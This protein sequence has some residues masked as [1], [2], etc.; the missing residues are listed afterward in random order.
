MRQF[1]SITHVSRRFSRGSREDPHPRRDSVAQPPA[2]RAACRARVGSRRSRGRGVGCARGG[3][4]RPRG[5]VRRSE[6][7]FAGPEAARSGGRDRRVAAGSRRTE[8]PRAAD[9]RRRVERERV[10]DRHGLCPALSPHPRF[11]KRT[12]SSS[13]LVRRSRWRARRPPEA[14]PQAARSP[15][16]CPGRAFDT[17]AGRR[18]ARASASGFRHAAGR[19]RRQGAGAQG[20]AARSGAAPAPA[21]SPSAAPPAPAASPAPSSEPAIAG[22][23]RRRSRKT[24]SVVGRV[25]GR[26]NRPGSRLTE[27]LRP[28][29]L[30][31]DPLSKEAAPAGNLRPLLTCFDR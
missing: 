25:G 18:R 1:P 29:L 9:R 19:R 21:A 7:P 24:A 5:R 17:A 16:R 13:R 6:Q 4:P 26:D 10:G 23:G 2:A 22:K 31:R 12:A 14:R 20:R 11:P 28:S 8:R 3:R 15:R 30:E 27:R